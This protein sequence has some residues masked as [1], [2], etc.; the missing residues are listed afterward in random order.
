VTSPYGNPRGGDP[1]DIRRFPNLDCS[2]SEARWRAAARWS[3]GDEDGARSLER[4]ADVL[5]DREAL[6]K[7]RWWWWPPP[8]PLSPAVGAVW[9]HAALE[10]AVGEAIEVTV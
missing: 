10:V 4:L 5:D 2:P 8:A 3:R 1:R 6:R 7:A 9:D